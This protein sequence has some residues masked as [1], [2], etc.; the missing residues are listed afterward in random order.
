MWFLRIFPDSV[1]GTHLECVDAGI[2]GGFGS[3]LAY[4]RDATLVLGQTPLGS[5]N[6]F[7][8]RHDA[9]G[10]LQNRVKI[11]AHGKR[12]VKG[13]SVGRTSLLRQLYLKFVS[14]RRHCR[15]RMGVQVGVAFSGSVYRSKWSLYGTLKM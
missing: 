14:T 15:E 8:H 3:L 5:I 4:N 2:I 13:R 7:Y 1:G 10:I 9:K 11:Y 12:T 6:Y